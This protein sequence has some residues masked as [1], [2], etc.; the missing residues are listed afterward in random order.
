M[1]VV[2]T[3]KNTNRL[4]F[5]GFK[6]STILLPAMQEKVLLHIH[7]KRD[8]K[9]WVF[10]IFF[11][12]LWFMNCKLSWTIEMQLGICQFWNFLCLYDLAMNACTQL[13]LVIA[14]ASNFILH[15]ISRIFFNLFNFPDF[16]STEILHASKDHKDDTDILEHSENSSDHSN[17][18]PR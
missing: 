5:C 11:G 17:F 7:A 3:L 1:M 18:F 15:V 2:G 8:G 16:I 10:K 12:Q 14:R 9:T 4:Y 13:F 6:F